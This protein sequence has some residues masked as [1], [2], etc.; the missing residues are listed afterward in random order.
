MEAG[1]QWKEGGGVVY[2]F[3]S[4][5]PPHL[6]Q[7]PH[8]LVTSVLYAPVNTASGIFMPAILNVS[9]WNLSSHIGFINKVSYYI[10]YASGSMRWF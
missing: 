7:H 6:Y 5:F 10:K 4:V 3:P 2:H 9:K 1:I 8:R